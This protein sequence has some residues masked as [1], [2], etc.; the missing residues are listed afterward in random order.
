MLGIGALGEIK[1]TKA[2]V[3]APRSTPPANLLVPMQVDAWVV[4]TAVT[5]PTDTQ[6]FQ[7]WQL[8][9]SRLANFQTVDPSSALSRFSESKPKEGV[10]LS[11]TLP[12]AL[13]HGH[14]KTQGDPIKF[15]LVPNRWLVVR[16]SGPED[17]RTSAA[18]ILESDTP[19]DKGTTFPSP[20]H[21]P[22]SADNPPYSIGHVTQIVSDSKK[23][24]SWIEPGKQTPFLT[25]V[26]NNDITF[27]MFQPYNANIFS[28]YIPVDT[29]QKTT[30]SYFV[31][32]WYSDSQFD[33]L[34]QGDKVLD[35]MKEYQWT[36][37]DSKQTP[38]Q[39][40][41][42]GMV[43]GIPWVWDE[44]S[45]P[46]SS[47]KEGQKNIV[48]QIRDSKIAVG[49]TVLEALVALIEKEDPSHSFIPPDLLKAL[50]SGLLDKLEECDG[51]EQ[52]AQKTHQAAFGSKPGGSIWS[53]TKED[54]K[55]DGS[56]KAL[57]ELKSDPTPTDTLNSLQISVE[58]D[59]R[60]LNA[61]QW[62]LYATW[63][64]LGYLAAD[65]DSDAYDLGTQQTKLVTQINILQ[66][67][68]KA[69]SDKI[70]A[71]SSK[72]EAHAKPHFWA[73]SDPVI[74]I[75]GIESP[76]PEQPQAKLPCRYSNE[77]LTTVF[78][79]TSRQ[80]IF[81]DINTLRAHLPPL[82]VAFLPGDSQGLLDE[83]S[84]WDWVKSKDTKNT[85]DINNS[86]YF[87]GVTPAY[88]LNSWI[89][90]WYPL[91]IKWEMTWYPLSFDKWQF[92]GGKD[93][94]CNY[95]LS[96]SVDTTTSKR[97]EGLG[98]L[99]PH[100]NFAFKGQLKRLLTQSP[101]VSP[102]TLN[103]WLDGIDNWP[104][105]AHSLSG[106]NEKIVLR[107]PVSHRTP[108][109]EMID[110][111]SVLDLIGEQHHS[112]PDPGP[113]P[114]P[115]S[116]TLPESSFQLLRQ[117]QFHFS[118]VSVIS[119]FGQNID[120][121]REET[122]DT[123]ILRSPG[124]K[125][126]HLINDPK[127][128]DKVLAQAWI[129]LPPRIIQAARLR[130]EW[131]PAKLG[132]DKILR[133]GTET[134]PV[135]GWLLPNY[136]DSA[137]QVYDP[138]GMCMG[139]VRRVEDEVEDEK[140]STK[141]VCLWET[142]P[143][144]GYTDLAS[145][146]KQYPQLGE[147]VQTLISLPIAAY[148]ALFEVFDLAFTT[149]TSV[150]SQASRFKAAFMGRPLAL[151]NVSWQ[152][153]LE[154][155]SYLDPSWGVVDGIK[156]EDYSFPIKLG[157]TNLNQDGLIGY[158]PQNDFPKSDFSQFLSD[159]VNDSEVFKNTNYIQQLT[160]GTPDTNKHFKLQP[161]FTAD[162]MVAN[163][164]TTLLI[165]PLASVHAYTDIL[166][167]HAIQLPA[168]FYTE[169][170][171][172]MTITFRMGPLLTPRVSLQTSVQIPNPYGKGGWSWLEPSIDAEGK[173]KWLEIKIDKTDDR[174]H[175]D[176]NKP[177]QLVEGLL[178]LTDGLKPATSSVLSSRSFVSSPPEVKGLAKGGS[179]PFFAKA[180]HN[181]KDTRDPA[182]YTPS[183]LSLTPATPRYAPNA[184]DSK[185][186]V[187]G[188]ERREI[189]EHQGSS[190][191][192]SSYTSFLKPSRSGVSSGSTMSVEHRMVTDNIGLT[193]AKSVAPAK[194]AQP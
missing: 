124:L 156:L 71:E 29:T 141:W 26:A 132:A 165:D 143:D 102:E 100:A 84:L 53:K 85:I 104:L 148:D 122:K 174:A 24:N 57:A 1:G 113:V 119:R 109:D 175:L 97:F 46:P 163:F 41:C 185:G 172:Q 146:H 8:K 115:D 103:K 110:T 164:V 88:G 95:D 169:A 2:Q 36:V 152:F 136:L 173:F 130:S 117:G 159:H 81:A 179:A 34:A 101:D 7:R 166:P 108:A 74:L 64:K 192:V 55:K 183:G 66:T 69:N 72:L 96:A 134:S 128:P 54:A 30:S 193:P 75:S 125:L 147:M 11:W 94:G 21:P 181:K 77:I 186:S 168:K 9:Y 157:N 105:L 37:S 126:N 140:D 188:S 80:H 39:M 99:T 180:P 73:P 52:N 176:S 67:Q 50:T 35:I 25:A 43:C 27:S 133:S 60:H 120:F 51:E 170:L 178:K 129:Q 154:Q 139:E 171:S 83:F 31:S 3:P 19:D 17:T 82:D 59:Q 149:K 47:T 153:E 150:D 191:V 16:Y 87:Q 135:C 184:G 38:Q 144:S 137:L 48:D 177:V 49:N 86:S 98:V 61:L 194:I 142:S 190:N 40:L 4:N 42:H 63:H 23:V 107:D 68:I 151:V 45:P 123:P 15:P 93:P 162:A 65:D 160:G 5:L 58:N 33:P 112:V 106:F 127:S 189:R 114:D 76:W 182:P 20:A 10:Y 44:N 79:D 161:V 167:V 78:T 155:P 111:H 22:P 116:S 32:G 89:Q 187:P 90:P 131:L 56:P 28:L 13:R 14:R 138:P 70:A 158:F 92:S 118:L 6:G 91:F 18:W 62:Q 121:I 145:I 12:T